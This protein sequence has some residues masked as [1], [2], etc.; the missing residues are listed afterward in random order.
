MVVLLY[1][2]KLRP[3]LC[4]AACGAECERSSASLLFFGVAII[5]GTSSLAGPQRYTRRDIQNLV[6]RHKLFTNYA[7]SSRTSEQVWK[8]GL[9][10]YCLCATDAPALFSGVCIGCRIL[11]GCLIVCPVYQ[12]IY[13]L[14]VCFAVCFSKCLPACLP[15][16]LSVCISVSILIFINTNFL[17]N[18]NWGGKKE[19]GLGV[20]GGAWTKHDRKDVMLRLSVWVCWQVAVSFRGPRKV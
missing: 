17:R 14:F 5:A 2:R 20:G 9:L 12:F 8:E 4:K 6:V 10:A 11:P 15:D 16:W 19:R 3:E 18:W 7:I 13:C 1:I